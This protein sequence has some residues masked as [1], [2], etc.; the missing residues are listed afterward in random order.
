MHDEKLYNSVKGKIEEYLKENTFMSSEITTENYKKAMIKDVL[1]LKFD[2]NS[3]I[4]DFEIIYCFDEVRIIRFNSS[5]LERNKEKNSIILVKNNEPVIRIDYLEKNYNDSIYS[6]EC[7]YIYD[8]NY[9]KDLFRINTLEKDNFR[10]EDVA[11]YMNISDDSKFLTKK[12]N[13]YILNDEIFSIGKEN[14]TFL[15]G[16]N[17]FN[18]RSNTL[19]KENNRIR[20]NV[21][22]V[23]DSVLG[24]DDVKEY[25]I[26]SKNDN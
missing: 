7:Y 3:I 25:K 14:K 11:L 20:I 24:F 17:S 5:N 1:G 8:K 2:K 16:D 18:S 22:N 23:V 26:K 12:Y 13:M 6:E 9:L 15:I 21:L 19:L 10:K 4:N